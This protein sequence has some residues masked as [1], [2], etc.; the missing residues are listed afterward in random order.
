MDEGDHPLCSSARDAVHELDP[1][2]REPR[3]RAG[4][5]VDDVTDVVKRRFGMLRDEPRDTRVLIRRLDELYSL[6]PVPEKHDAN[7][8]V[9]ELVD[10][11]GR[12]PEGVSKE[13]ERLFDSLHGDRD[14]VQRSE[15]HSRGGA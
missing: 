11:I 8:L 7:A 10:R 9:R 6:V 14:V 5:I 13:W 1:L 3:E 4:Q 2:A 15:L 12:K